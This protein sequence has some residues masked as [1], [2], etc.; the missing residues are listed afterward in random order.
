MW[1]SVNQ[2]FDLSTYLQGLEEESLLTSCSDTKLSEPAKSKSTQEKSCCNDNGT[3]SCQGSQSG[4]MSAPSMED[5]GEEQLTLFAEA[6]PAKTSVQQVRVQ[7]LPEHV[8][9]FGRST[10]ESLMRY[11]LSMSLPKTHHCFALGDLE[12]SSKT[13]PKWGTM[14]DGACWELGTSVRP[15]KEIGCGYTLPTPVCNPSKRK[16]TN[17]KSLSAKGVRYGISMYQICGGNPDPQLEE[18]MMG[19]PLGWTDLKPLEM[20]KFQQW[21]H[22]HSR[23]SNS[24]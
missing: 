6:S 7:E 14:Q 12:L 5:R 2:N 17:G 1:H 22:L 21:Q 3:E 20:D 24:D 11:G 23:F 18:W 10:Q 8:Q 15:I 19:W 9:D 13:W 4:T 16:L